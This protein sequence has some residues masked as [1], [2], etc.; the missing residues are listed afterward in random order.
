MVFQAETRHLSRGLRVGKITADRSVS[1]RQ[2]SFLRRLEPVERWPSLAV[3][4]FGIF[5]GA[6]HRFESVTT[7]NALCTLSGDSPF[8][9]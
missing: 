8:Y 1:D 4:R 9:L 3:P 6:R 2:R 7:V 5:R